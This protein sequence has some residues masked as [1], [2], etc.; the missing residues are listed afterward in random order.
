MPHSYYT[1]FEAGRLAA[2]DNQPR[3]RI[4]I[5]SS[6]GR[7]LID[8]WFE[9]YDAWRGVMAWRER[10]RID[11][12]NPRCIEVTYPTIFNHSWTVHTR[13]NNKPGYVA[14]GNDPIRVQCE[15]VS[16]DDLLNEVLWEYLDEL[17][18]FNC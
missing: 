18:L 13:E 15:S 3:D 16:M 17:A 11:V 4:S 8:A 5:P 1:A 6:V 10:M 7:E 14:F 9:G 2:V 12:L